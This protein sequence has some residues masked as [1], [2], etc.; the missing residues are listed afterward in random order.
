MDEYIDANEAAKLLGKNYRQLLYLIK[1]KKLPA[2]KVGWAW[3]IKRN[4]VE[5]LKIEK[6]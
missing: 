4:D 2:D 6:I 3:V 1:S 5:Q